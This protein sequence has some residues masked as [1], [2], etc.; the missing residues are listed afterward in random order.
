MRGIP[1]RIK[2]ARNAQTRQSAALQAQSTKITTCVIANCFA[3]HINHLHQYDTIICRKRQFTAGDISWYTTTKVVPHTMA[4]IEYD[5]EAFFQEY[6]KMTRSQR[7]LADACEWHMLQPLFPDLQCKRVLDL[8]CCYGWHCKYAVEQGAAQVLGI[9]ISHKM[10][11]ESQKR[12]ADPKIEYRL[13]SIADYDYPAA[14]WDCVVSN[15]ALHYI[16]DL[17]RVFANVHRTLK[18][19][20]TFLFYIEHP[21]FT[22]GVHQGWVYG[23]NGR[24]LYWPIDNYFLPGERVTNFLGCGIRKQHHTLTQILMGLL[25]IGFVLEAVEE[26]EP[27]ANMMDLPGMK[28]ELR[29]PMLLVKATEEKNIKYNCLRFTSHDVSASRRQFQLFMFSN[30]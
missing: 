16:A 7:G 17:D 22:A 12:N 14:A 27:P 28:D 8:G 10:L 15:L 30:C 3:G 24:L 20:G 13:C 5:N 29:R 2:N 6:A 21:S 25:R 4:D 26:A 1:H 18:S 19:D 11:D 9:G 23:T